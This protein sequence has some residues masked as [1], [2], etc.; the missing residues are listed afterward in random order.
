MGQ[1]LLEGTMLSSIAGLVGI[2]IGTVAAPF[3]SSVLLPTVGKSLGLGTGATISISASGTAATSAVTVSPELMLIA[4]GVAVL[5]GALGSLY[6]AWRAARTRP[7]E[8]MRYE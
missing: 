4:F 3:L 6:P 8:A 5:L 7:A 1:F 2:A